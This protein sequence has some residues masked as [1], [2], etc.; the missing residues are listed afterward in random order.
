[1]GSWGVWACLTRA[2]HLHGASA[3]VPKELLPPADGE[4]CC[5]GENPYSGVGALKVLYG[6]LAPDGSV[7]K[8]AA[9][10]PSML[11]H[12]GP[13]RVFDSE[14]AACAAIGAGAIVPE[15]WW[16]SATSG[17]AGGPACAML[18]PTSAICGM[19]LSTSVALITDGA[20]PA[21]PKAGRGPRE[22]EAAAGGPIALICEDDSI[23][24]DI[25]GGAL[26]LN[27]SDEEPARRRAAWGAPGAQTRCGRAGL[28]TR[29]W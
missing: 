2:P 3:R 21:P 26:T 4:V 28:S 16:S 11:R 18:S 19:G 27:V 7:V 9:V 23:T 12:T 24:V 10:D 20:S 1:M 15:T 5:T 22:P 14:E 13:A 8:K 29:N 25:E 17:L 6:N